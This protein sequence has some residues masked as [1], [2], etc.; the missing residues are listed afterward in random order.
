MP[1]FSKIPGKL[2]K[3]NPAYLVLFNAFLHNLNPYADVCSKT[4]RSGSCMKWI[5]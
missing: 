4:S 3:K 5:L 1:K 2:K